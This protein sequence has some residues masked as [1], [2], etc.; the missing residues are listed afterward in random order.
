MNR[1]RGFLVFDTLYEVDDAL[2]AQ[3][4]MVEGHAIEDD[5]KTWVMTLRPG[6]TFHDNEPVLARDVTASL[7]RWTSR[8][9]FGS[10]LFSIVDDR[11]RRTTTVGVGLDPGSALAVLPGVGANTT[12][13][14]LIG[15]GVLRIR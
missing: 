14:M 3:P 2:R 15:N 6:L 12:L 10:S 13:S 7:R 9:T 11:Q 8:D 5:G 1:N 4:Q